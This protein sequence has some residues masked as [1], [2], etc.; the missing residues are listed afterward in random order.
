MV[1]TP[2]DGD[3]LVLATSV[4]Q[5]GPL[6]PVAWDG[7]RQHLYTSSTNNCR[8]SGVK[9]GLMAGVTE[10]TTDTVAGYT[11]W[12]QTTTS[13]NSYPYPSSLNFVQP[14]IVLINNY[15]DALSKFQITA[16]RVEGGAIT[17][18]SNRDFPSTDYATTGW[19]RGQFSTPDNPQVFFYGSGSSGAVGE[20]WETTVG[21]DGSLSPF[22]SRG[23]VTFIGDFAGSAKYS[24]LAND[25]RAINDRLAINYFGVIFDRQNPATLRRLSLPPP[26]GEFTTPA[27][28]HYANAR[29]GPDHFYAVFQGNMVTNSDR[30]YR[31]V[32]YTVTGDGST[33]VAG[34]FWETPVPSVSV[35]FTPTIEWGVVVSQVI[36]TPAS[37]RVWLDAMGT[38]QEFTEDPLLPPSWS[39]D[40]FVPT[41]PAGWIE[42]SSTYYLE[43]VEKVPPPPAVAVEQFL[44]GWW[45]RTAGRIRRAN[46]NTPIR[47]PPAYLREPRP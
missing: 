30:L 17:V 2:I 46:D 37:R 22:V 20:V 18:L 35:S 7:D 4:G 32:E 36:R 25:T 39:T 27:I 29:T 16:I 43:V 24:A 45:D 8:Y 38:P 5:F 13:N 21:V 19:L 3:F 28:T 42:L 14:G 6:V 33:P 23:P 1:T 41:G 26:G 44:V 40:S 11:G 10:T 34:S 47:V 31:I 15:V 12:S 9:T